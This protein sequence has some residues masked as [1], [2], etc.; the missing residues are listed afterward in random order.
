M[1]SEGAGITVE[2]LRNI[3]VVKTGGKAD[4]NNEVYFLYSLINALVPGDDQ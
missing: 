1:Y 2:F 3:H 4:K